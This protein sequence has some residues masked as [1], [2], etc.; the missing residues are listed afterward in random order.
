MV[1]LGESAPVF[2]LPATDGEEITEVA[3]EREL[4]KETI[5]LAFFPLA[6]S[7]VCTEELCEFRDSP[8]AFNTVQAKVFGISVD[9]PFAL[10]EFARQNGLKFPLL[11]DFNKEVAG[12]YGV[13]HE[14]L[15]G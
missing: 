15:M 13:L 5:V 6:F 12:A 2:T 11:S 1:E 4:G 8:A 7:P 10:K 3:L 14:E 9:S